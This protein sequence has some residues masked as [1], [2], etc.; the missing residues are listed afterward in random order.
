[1][2][3]FEARTPAAPGRIVVALNGECD[4]AVRDELTSALDI[5]S[6]GNPL[7]PT[8]DDPRLVG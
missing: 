7:R 4:L 1:M 2:A 3:H 6:V 5:T 8:V